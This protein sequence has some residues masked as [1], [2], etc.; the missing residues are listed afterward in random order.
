MLDI[1]LVRTDTLKIKEKLHT[2]GMTDQLIDELLILD[3]RRREL[4]STSDEMK[5]ERNESSKQIGFLIKEGRDVADLKE[6]V[7]ILSDKFKTMDQDLKD[8]EVKQHRILLSIPNLPH[9]SVPPGKTEQDNKVVSEWGEKPQFDFKPRFHWEIGESLD[10][11]DFPRA[12]K[13][14]GANFPLL[15]GGLARLER[16]LISWMIDLHV[17]E[18]GYVEIAPPYLVN[19]NTMIG[20][21]QLPKLEEDMYR[22]EVDD[23]FL[24][25]TAEV[26]VTNLHSNEILNAVNLPMYYVAFTPCFR[27]EAGSYGKETRGLTRVHQFSKVEMVKMV[28]PETS[29]EELESLRKNAEDVLRR[30]GLHYRVIELCTGELSFSASKC[31]DLEVWAPGMGR[32]LEVSSCSNFEDYQARRMQI[33]FR[34]ESGAKVELIHT[35]N[36]SG[37]ALPRTLIAIL[38]TYQRPD[39]TVAIPEALRPYYGSDVLG[40][41]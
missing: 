14:T 15:K 38:E 36:G 18:Q 22:C 17:R 41:T 10:I 13:I 1:H 29:Y 31:Y 23:F 35:L 39:G 5:K 7:R 4:Q 40:N 32:Y 28:L 20:T 2:K 33:R 3:S 30:L 8:L 12:T 16:C 11:L 19:R 25:P 21:G 9:D 26:P 27:R 34:R 6:A 24:I 37:L